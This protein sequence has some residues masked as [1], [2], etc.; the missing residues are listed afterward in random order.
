MS[1]PV[2][3]PFRRRVGCST[4]AGTSCAP[5]PPPRN[6]RGVPLP[7]SARDLHPAAAKFTQPC[8]ATCGCMQIH[9]ACAAPA[10]I[11]CSLFG[12]VARF[13]RDLVHIREWTMELRYLCLQRIKRRF[14]SGGLGGSKVAQLSTFFTRGVGFFG[15]IGFTGIMDRFVRRLALAGVL[16]HEQAADCS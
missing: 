7:R 10:L 16:Q 1:L 4:S 12:Q 11:P 9:A 14:S 15:T 2:E 8:G 6:V 5:A 3:W 13:A